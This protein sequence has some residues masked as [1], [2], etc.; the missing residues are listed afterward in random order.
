MDK[1]LEV[2]PSFLSAGASVAAAVTAI[3]ALKIS[4]ESKILA[5][6]SALATHHNSAS[7]E[8]TQAVEELKAPIKEISQYA[9]SC[10]VSWTTEIEK[11]D[12]RSNVG[13]NPRPLRHVLFDSIK[14]LTN[15]AR[16]M[17]SGSGYSHTIM[18]DIVRNGGPQPVEGEFEKLMK[19]ADHCYGSFESVFG[20][21][22][23][24]V[25]ISNSEAFR[26]SFFQLSKRV[27]LSN[28]IDNWNHA[29]NESG[30]IMHLEKMLKSLRPKFEKVRYSLLVEESKLAN[31]VFPLHVNERLQSKYDALKK[32]LDTL[33]I[34][35]NLEQLKVYRDSG[36]E[37]DA[38]ELILYTLGLMELLSQ[39][40]D[41]LFRIQE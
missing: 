32:I 12:E 29:W 33:L 2:L 36:L 15:H 24:N 31:T 9:Y 35:S 21:P 23:S 30:R 17:A 7:S 28:W 40:E 1:W 5:T 13:D 11:Y 27:A 16:E 14:M 19:I 6:H 38:I 18:F 34:D 3:V 26:W 41:D 22:S 20:K 4:R 10:L 8:L 39:L 25:R 37:I